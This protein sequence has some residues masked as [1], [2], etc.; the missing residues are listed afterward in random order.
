MPTEERPRPIARVAVD[1]SLSHLDRPFDYAVPDAQ[2]AVAVPGARVR[3]RFAGRM[4]DGFI[5]DRLAQTHHSGE[6]APLSKVI[7]A[8]PV[9][10]SEVASLIR[11]VA[12]HYAGTFADV[13]RL[14]VPP[15]HAATEQARRAAFD[16]A[17][18][19]IDPC[20]DPLAD[21]PT[22]AA[23][24]A[25]VRRGADPRAM[26][27]VTPFAGPGGDWTMGLANAAR[28]CADSGR[29]AVIVVPDARDLARLEAACVRTLGPGGFR[30]LV[31]EAGP[32]A[33]Y[34][35]FLAA[36]RGDVPVII[37]N[38][39]AAFAPVRRLGL[40]ALWDDGDDLLVEQRAPYPH[41][42]DVLAIR[43]AE[44][45]AAVLFASYGRT[46]EQQAWLERGWLRE[47]SQE[48][49]LV[50]HDA[51]RVKV[52]IDSDYA[53]AHDPA[54][55]SARLPHEVFEVMRA[56]L[57]QGPV[58]VQVPRVGYLVTLVCQGCREPVR[59]RFCAGP[60][61]V[62]SRS[63]R[64][65]EPAQATCDWCGR[66]Q[67]NWEC[68]ICG[69]RGMRAPVVGA[70]RTAEELGK[71]FPSTPV[72]QVLAGTAAATMPGSSAIVVAT[73]GTEPPADGGYAAAVL[74]DAQLLLLRRDLR[75][76]EEALRRWLNVVA[77]VRGGV[78]GG[79]VIAVGDSSAR[80]LQALVR[81]DPAGFAARELSERVEAGFPPAVRMVAVEGPPDALDEF[82]KLIK[83]P[84]QADMMG[85]IDLAAAGSP[86]PQIS[87]LIL[88][89]PRSAARALA[90][91]AKEVAAIRSAR[92][93][94]L[95]LR[96]RVDP[97]VLE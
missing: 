2:D 10:T 77:L 64:G 59:C 53:L 92:K 95:P 62:G 28:A 11:K 81:V 34:R 49:T 73:P 96:I 71:A 72:R 25:A 21:Y 74:L 31:A 80:A 78:E 58:L 44:A 42:R 85:P 36:S 57:P 89:A 46:A 18:P 6:L 20:S 68:P 3:V 14:A 75:A 52:A 15:R 40:V 22:G 94:E 88:R 79:S 91:A 69:S 38:R 67:I 93:S 84:P 65:E 56:A 83:L 7:S 90:G 47:L 8:E 4:R 16:E 60:T 70:S 55:A 35:A 48:R 5:L 33:R 82:R 9:L 37:G 19:A 27:Q 13:M 97:V 39:A 30:V 12:D 43:A 23:Y 76:A 87:R 63:A 1:V 54:A 24:L 45:R 66:L 32:A 41:A 50:R 51:P 29:G 86:E 26:W 17:M 61:G